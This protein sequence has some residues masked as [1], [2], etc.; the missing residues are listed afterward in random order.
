MQHELDVKQE[1]IRQ[2]NEQITLLHKEEETFPEFQ[3]LKIAAKE[4]DQKEHVLSMV[5]HQVKE[6][7]EVVEISAKSLNAIHLEVQTI[8]S[9]I[10]LA[11]RFDVFMKVKE[12]LAEYQ[13]LL[14]KLQ[15]EHQTYLNRLSDIKGKQEY[16]QDIKVDIDEILYDQ[17]QAERQC[18]EIKVQRDLVIDQLSL[19]DYEEIKHQLDQCLERI[20]KLPA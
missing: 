10:Y 16:A 15:L 19:T 7:Q 2:N 11:V 4:F 6:Q 14:M 9:G 13:N 1:E 5:E 8:C 20:A 17:G 18:R 12:S 3:D